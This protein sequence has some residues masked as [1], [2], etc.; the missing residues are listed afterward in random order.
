MVLVIGVHPLDDGL[1][2][3][4]ADEDTEHPGPDGVIV[5][6]EVVGTKPVEVPLVT[7]TE[8]V[9]VLVIGEH[10]LEDGLDDD[11]GLVVEL[12][13]V[14][15]DELELLLLVLVVLTIVLD[16]PV[17]LSVLGISDVVLVGMG[18]L[19]VLVIETLTDV[20]HSLIQGTV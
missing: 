19:D 5:V 2:D 1:D 17:V 11:N 16:L 14:D 15:V 10:P 4:G 12:G 6:T 18:V 20:P 13:T 8:L 7:G 9:M 3:D